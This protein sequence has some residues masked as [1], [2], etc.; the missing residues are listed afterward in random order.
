MG[1]KKAFIYCACLFSAGIIF[2][3]IAGDLDPSFLRY[4]WGT[5]GA[6]LYVYLL[7]VFNYSAD[8]YPRLHKFYDRYACVASLASMVMITV[9]F[10]LVRQDVHRTGLLSALGF[11][12]MTAS[13]PF[14][15]LLIYFTTTLGLNLVEDLYHFRQRKP[16]LMLLHSCVFVV[17]LAGIFGSGDKVRVRVSAQ[18]NEPTDTGTHEGKPYL[19]PFTI[20][21][22]AF[23]MEEY[24]AKIH[25]VDTLSGST[26]EAHITLERAGERGNLGEWEI[27]AERCY[28]T[29]VPD[30]AGFRELE[31]IGAAPA[32]RLH[33]LNRRTKRQASGW[34]SCGSF[35]FDP[36]YLMVDDRYALFMPPRT[37]KHYLSDISVRDERGKIHPFRI[38]VN[39]P[40]RMGS[41][42]IYQ[43]GYDT[44]RG[45]WSTSSV[46][47]CVHDSWYQAVRIALWLLLLTGA[48]ILFAAGDRRGNAR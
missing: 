17:L 43:A 39:H 30:S 35:L 12:R 48:W 37:A 38:T 44:R 16:V 11:T 6:A 8:R 28:E 14:N 19:L 36:S 26:S 2:Q 7:F 45:R 22:H 4:P 20:T 13:W 42:Y 24:P 46:F 5:I 21:L 33:A 3:F 29:A 10:G 15:I 1:Y 47:E 34:V 9:L 23:S 18:Q 40:A 27:K 25:M 41:W 31:H 32:L